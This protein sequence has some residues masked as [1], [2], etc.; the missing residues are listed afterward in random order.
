MACDGSNTYGCS[1]KQSAR[2]TQPGYYGGVTM[3]WLKSKTIEKYHAL[4][5]CGLLTGTDE[6]IKLKAVQTAR[7]IQ[8]GLLEEEKIGD[9]DFPLN[10]VKLHKPAKFP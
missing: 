1:S 4:R 10:K 5:G 2:T 7:L 3:E 9:Y 6:E 8:R